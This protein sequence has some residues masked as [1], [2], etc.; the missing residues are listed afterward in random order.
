MDKEQDKEQ[1]S[2]LKDSGKKEEVQQELSAKQPAEGRKKLFAGAKKDKPTGSGA[3]SEKKEEPEQAVDK[4]KL[5]KNKTVK[6][7]IIAGVIA[8]LAILICVYIYR[9]DYYK[10]LTVIVPVG[11]LTFT[12]KSREDDSYYVTFTAADYNRIPSEVNEKGARVRV[13]RETY[14]ILVLK[15]EYDSA[16]V[17]FEVPQGVARKVGYSPESTNYQSLWTEDILAK[18]TTI[19]TIVW[20][21]G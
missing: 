20:K 4:A 3:E 1:Q 18:Y 13:D 6:F 14:D 15:V 17:I 19:K 10:K 5:K 21:A 2:S 8:V 7:G 9:A 11:D 12:D 16:D